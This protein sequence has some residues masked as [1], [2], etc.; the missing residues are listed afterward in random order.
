MEDFQIASQ[1]SRD[2]FLLNRRHIPPERMKLLSRNELLNLVNFIFLFPKGNNFRNRYLARQA[3]EQSGLTFQP[4][5]GALSLANAKH[6]VM[7]NT[8]H[9]VDLPALQRLD[10]SRP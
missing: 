9:L 3:L 2:G 1:L 5:K 7:V 8:V 10:H 6:V 4:L